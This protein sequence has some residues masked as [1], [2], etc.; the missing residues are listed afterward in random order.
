MN[1]KKFIWCLSRHL[2]G[3]VKTEALRNRKRYRRFKT[4]G[5]LALNS[6]DSLCRS[7]DVKYWLMFGTLLGGFREKGFLKHDDDIDVGMFES[8]ITTDFIKKMAEKGFVLKHAYV[9]KSGKG[10][11]LA[12]LYEGVK[13]D[14]YSYTC[15]NQ[16]GY[17]F[18]PYPLNGSWKETISEKRASVI[19]VQLLIAGFKK[20][21]FEGLNLTVPDNCEDVL[22]RIY[23]DS[24]MIP[25]P[26]YKPGPNFFME[27]IELDN[28]YSVLMNCSEYHTY[29]QN[30]ESIE[31]P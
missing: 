22:R 20:I 28:D 3:N 4:S 25:Q 30:K 26:G 16:Q 18:L 2:I 10:M 24:F 9:A 31:I 13:F 11:H 15:V 12:F 23:G 1:I 27:K 19:H 21:A 5:I 14:I 7:A 6:F 8:N 17:I 29:L